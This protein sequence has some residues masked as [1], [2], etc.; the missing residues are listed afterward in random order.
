MSYSGLSIKKGLMLPDELKRSLKINM[1]TLSSL[2]PW[3]PIGKFCIIS[4]NNQR[5]SACKFDNGIP[6]CKHLEV[7]L[8]IDSIGGVPV[9]DIKCPRYGV[10][11]LTGNKRRKKIETN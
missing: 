2:P 1:T 6:Y 4:F 8:H 5:C 11:N 7:D 10:Y 3:I 9:K